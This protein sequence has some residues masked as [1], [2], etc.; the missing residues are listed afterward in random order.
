MVSNKDLLEFSCV[1]E[2]REEVRDK[3]TQSQ[4]ESAKPTRRSEGAGPTVPSQPWTE[5][6]MPFSLRRRELEQRSRY[7]FIEH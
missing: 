6:G 5:E 2:E 4:A 1:Q 7:K 3:E